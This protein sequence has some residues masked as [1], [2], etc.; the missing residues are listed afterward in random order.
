MNP[1]N[2]FS[3][4]CSLLIALGFSASPQIAAAAAMPFKGEASGDVVGIPV[5]GTSLYAVNLSGTGK[6]TEMGEFA[7]VA[8]HT[9]DG[10]TGAITAGLI[11]FAAKNGDTLTGTYAGQE[12]PT[13]SPDM[14]IVEA[15]LTITGGTGRFRGASGTVPFTAVVTIEE[16]TK[17]G[18]FI[19]T[20]EAS[21]DG[22]LTL[23]HSEE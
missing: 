11:T 17:K 9:T 14:A 16:I 1:I 13:D 22:R 3:R 21:F 18:V 4:V 8:S 7:V 5:K 10:A 15:T 20:F 23:P 6:A 2:Y 12:F 19:E